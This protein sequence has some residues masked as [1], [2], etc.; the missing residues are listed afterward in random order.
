MARRCS[1]SAAGCARPSA[2]WGD[3]TQAT[4]APLVPGQPTLMR[5]EIQKFAHVFRAGSS[6]R[7]TIDSP[8][9]TGFWIFG[10]DK[11]PSTNTLWHDAQHASSIV[12]GHVPYPHAQAL[13]DCGKTLRQ[14]GRPNQVPVPAGVGP[15]APV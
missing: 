5:V 6:L 7:V 12:L 13:P 1:S 11:T 8:S 15:K 9:Q 4:D 2:P 10:N 3:F 14:P